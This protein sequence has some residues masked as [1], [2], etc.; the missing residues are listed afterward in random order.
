MQG[1]GRKVW[2]PLTCNPSQ[3]WPSPPCS[4]CCSH[5]LTPAVPHWWPNWGGQWRPT[6]ERCFSFQTT[7]HPQSSPAKTLLSK[8]HIFMDKHTHQ[9]NFV[10]RSARV[11]FIF[12]LNQHLLRMRKMI[13]IRWTLIGEGSEGRLIQI[14][15][16][17]WVVLVF[18]LQADFGAMQTELN[19][20][21]ISAGL[22]S[23]GRAVFSGSDG[24]P[25]LVDFR[26]LQ[27][28]SVISRKCRY[29]LAHPQLALS[30]C[31]DLD[32][33]IRSERGKLFGK[34]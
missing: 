12:P 29:R 21:R 11:S 2:P 24:Q 31:L 5:S 10:C 20:T 17:H 8:I 1:E 26:K 25:D 27:H 30:R 19:W 3:S 16:E 22:R 15:G 6:A 23:G 34:G 32:N 4:Y 14:G 13:L 28:A 18:I 33:D 9:V 7:L